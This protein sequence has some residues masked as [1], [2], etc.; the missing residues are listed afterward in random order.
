MFSK[1]RE[2]LNSNEVAAQFL[3]E[4]AALAQKRDLMSDEHF[5]VDGTLLQ[6][7][8][9]HKS[10]RPNDEP[11]SG[12]D[13]QR[14][15]PADLRRQ[16]RKNDTH[17]STSDPDKRLYRKGNTGA[18]LSYQGHVLMENRNG[19]VRD[20]RPT[21]ASGHGERDA[22]LTMMDGCTSRAATTHAGIEQWVD[23]AEFVAKCRAA[24]VTPHV[25]QNT[26]NRRAVRSMVARPGIAAMR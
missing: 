18:Q 19:L 10:F 9:S 7:W 22:A 15:A 13:G 17:A 1:N 3:R 5:S 23:S 21:H 12:G 14:N 2:R 26:S 11:P 25:A 16:S 8:A 20:A 4:V 6:A 24:G